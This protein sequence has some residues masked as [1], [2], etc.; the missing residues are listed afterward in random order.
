MPASHHDAAEA[1]PDAPATAR[2]HVELPRVLGLRDLVLFNIVAVVNLNL[3]P[4]FAAGGF[5]ALTLL[6]LALLCFL[7]P[8]GVAVSA[9]VRKYPHEG[10]IYV[11]TKSSFGEFH[12]FLCG[13]CYWL[14]NSFYVPTLLFY[15][16]GVAV[17]VGG[18]QSARLMESRTFVPVTALLLLWLFTGL[19]VRGLGVGKWVN[20]LGG[21][22]AGVTSLALMGVGIA[23]LTSSTAKAETVRSSLLPGFADWGT[24]SAFSTICLAM[25]G[26]EL[27]STMAAEI[28]DPARNVPRSALLGGMACGVLYLCAT[29]AMLLALPPSEISVIQGVLQAVE[30]ITRDLGAAWMVAPLAAVLALSIAGASSAWL[31]GGARVPFV[32]GL[33]R[34]LPAALGKTHRRWKT[35]HVAL[36]A[37]AAISSLFILFSLF[38]VNVFEAYV[39]L[40]RLTVDTNLIPFLYLFAGAIRMARGSGFAWLTVNGYVGLFTTLLAMGVTFLPDERIENVWLFEAKLLGGLAIFLGAAV[41]FFLIYSRRAAPA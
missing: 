3:V 21:V 13:W 25:I 18:T 4:A 14:T 7:L 36:L 20:N 26:L 17:Y 16:V 8:Q 38:G 5:P 34:F 9:F 19:C 31:A 6:L 11:W 35:P 28:K 29:L 15:L 24:I 12:G 10:G 41:A 22:A 40:L 33:D 39:T 30:R 27:S 1:A 37:Q 2:A 23:A 32:A